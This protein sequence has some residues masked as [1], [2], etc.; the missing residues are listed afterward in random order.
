MAQLGGLQG[1]QHVMA[2]LR[3]CKGGNMSWHSWGSAREATIYFINNGTI[4]TSI[5]RELFC[6]IMYAFTIEKS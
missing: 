6:C 2:Q 1:R 5:L 4:K 3:V